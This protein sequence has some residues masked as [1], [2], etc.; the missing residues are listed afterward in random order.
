M[1]ENNLQR[2]V[3]EALDLRSSAILKDENEFRRL[4]VEIGKSGVITGM[5]THQ[6]LNQKLISTLTATRR[7]S[8][9]LMNTEWY[10]DDL[11]QRVTRTMITER[12]SSCI[13]SMVETKRLENLEQGKKHLQC[14]TGDFINNLQK[15][16][17][18][19]A[20]S[21]I[22][23]PAIPAMDDGTLPSFSI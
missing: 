14:K 7:R 15:L 3:R 9:P 8:A 19:S 5:G 10:G 22:L 17:P 11:N 13:A 4:K 18:E 12:R 20:I 21:K 16:S 2:Q 6:Y 1:K 23:S